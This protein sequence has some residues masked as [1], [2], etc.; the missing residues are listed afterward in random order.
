[1]PTLLFLLEYKKNYTS[2]RL[3]NLLIVGKATNV[4]LLNLLSNFKNCG[5]IGLNIK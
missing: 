5:S 1:M 4:K 2:G 3:F